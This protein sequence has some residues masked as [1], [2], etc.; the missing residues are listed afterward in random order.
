MFYQGCP[1]ARGL[2]GP[3]LIGVIMGGEEDLAVHI[4]DLVGIRRQEVQG[5]HGA[6]GCSGALFC[7]NHCQDFLMP[8]MM[9]AKICEPLQDLAREPKRAKGDLQWKAT[10]EAAFSQFGVTWPPVLPEALEAFRHRREGE[11]AFFA[12]ERFPKGE[13]GTWS[14]FDTNHTFERSFRWPLGEGE[15]LRNPWKPFIPT[16]TGSSAIICRKHNFD[17]S[18]VLKRL[19]GLE[20]M[21][22]IGWDHSFWKG[23]VSPFLGSGGGVS[24]VTPELLSDLAGN[25]WSAFGFLPLVV[26]SFGAAPWM[27]YRCSGLSGSGASLAAQGSGPTPVSVVDSDNESLTPMD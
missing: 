5:H 24:P 15:E 18:V 4:L 19:H 16:L 10:H 12:H 2:G 13:P 20:A 17:G 25:A 22:V 26:A 9:I 8:D 1:E 7:S 6:R 27:S 23:G 21:R 14:F 3:D 11:V